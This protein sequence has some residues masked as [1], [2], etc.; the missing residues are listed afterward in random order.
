M[1]LGEFKEL[2]EKGMSNSEEKIL[3][4]R[5]CRGALAISA[6]ENLIYIYVSIR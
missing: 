4:V 1:I 3:F 6:K 2:F 5:K